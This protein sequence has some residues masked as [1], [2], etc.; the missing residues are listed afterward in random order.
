MGKIR[1]APRETLEFYVTDK[2]CLV[3][4]YVSTCTGPRGNRSISKNYKN[5]ATFYLF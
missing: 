3:S 1:G 2:K 4:S 5:F